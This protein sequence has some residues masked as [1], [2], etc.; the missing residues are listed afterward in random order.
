M[1]PAYSTAR[2][3]YFETVHTDGTENEN[4]EEETNRIIRLMQYGGGCSTR[5][6]GIVRPV[7]ERVR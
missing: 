1:P 6:H 3:R 2:R 7:K 5:I 4:D